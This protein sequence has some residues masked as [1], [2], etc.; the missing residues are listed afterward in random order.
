MRGNH[1]EPALA[2]KHL[3]DVELG[4][5][6]DLDV[7]FDVARLLRSFV[8]PDVRRAVGEFREQSES[9]QVIP[10]PTTRAEDPAQVRDGAAA[11]LTGEREHDR[12]DQRRPDALEPDRAARRAEIAETTPEEPVEMKLSVLFA[13]DALVDFGRGRHLAFRRSGRRVRRRRRLL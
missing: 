11:V 9:A 6:D 1:D 13:S 5:R 3:L 12:G 8:L 7:A 4:R 2:R 10:E